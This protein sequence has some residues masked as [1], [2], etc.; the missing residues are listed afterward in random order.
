MYGEIARD[1][2]GGSAWCK[3]F[4]FVVVWKPT[5]AAQG[6]TGSQVCRREAGMLSVWPTRVPVSVAPASCA[7]QEDGKLRPRLVLTQ[8]RLADEGLSSVT[9]VQQCSSV[10][11]PGKTTVSHRVTTPPTAQSVIEEADH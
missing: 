9:E 1:L 2:A 5:G 6:A 7:L 11:V 8:S 3:Q 10:P 4:C